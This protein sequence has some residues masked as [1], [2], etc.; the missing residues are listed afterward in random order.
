[1]SPTRPE[2]EEDAF[3]HGSTDRSAAPPRQSPVSGPAEVEARLEL[4]LA[5][6]RRRGGVLALLCVRVEAIACTHCDVSADMEQRVRQEVCKRIG[7]AVRGGDAI[8]RESERDT[9]V[10]LPGADATVAERV[11]KR[12]ARLVNGDY[13]VA[14]ELLH[15]VVRVGRAAHPDNGQR[16]PDLLRHA[17]GAD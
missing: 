14:G 3:R 17:S 15:V 13:R 4:H 8:L 10:V 6:C 2:R 12:L 7:N 1:M 5:Q 16:A 9:C 11:G